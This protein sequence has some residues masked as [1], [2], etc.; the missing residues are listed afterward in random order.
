MH[1]DVI[2]VAVA[3]SSISRASVVTPSGSRKIRSIIHTTS[4]RVGAR[5]TIYLV[6]PTRA[7]AKPNEFDFQRRIG[8]ATDGSRFEIS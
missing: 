8:S 1:I 4:Q 2:Y 3:A 6:A 7:H 5:E